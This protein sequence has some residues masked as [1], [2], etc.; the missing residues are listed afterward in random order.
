MFISPT[1][2]VLYYNQDTEGS[3]IIFDEKQ[4]TFAIINM[5][6]VQL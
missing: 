2:G 6:A 1:Y 5:T 4:K 3:E